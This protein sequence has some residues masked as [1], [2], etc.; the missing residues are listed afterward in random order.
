MTQP[1]PEQ[2]VRQLKKAVELLGISH[3]AV[4]ARSDP[5][6]VQYE[7]YVASVGVIPDVPQ[8][9]RRDMTDGDPGEVFMMCHERSRNG[10]SAFSSRLVRYFVTDY[11]YVPFPEE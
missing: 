11:A 2:T 4:M 1:T 6:R 8:S 5:R 10:G 3:I 9:E 7:L